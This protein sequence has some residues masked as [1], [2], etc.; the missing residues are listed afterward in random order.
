MKRL[1][2]TALLLIVLTVGA[3]A[4]EGSI[5]L[6]T[7]QEANDCDAT[8]TPYLSSEIH[9]MYFKSTSGPDGIAGAHFRVEI[10]AGGNV[11]LQSFTLHPN[12]VLSLGTV[13][14]AG[15]SVS[16]SGCTGAGADVLLIGTLTV[17]PMAAGNYTF[18]VLTATDIPPVID[19]P[20]AP[21]VAICDEGRSLRAVLG[22]WYSTPD[23]TCNVGTE[24][25]TWGAIKEM[26]KE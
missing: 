13:D 14:G 1:A 6:F 17:F 11:V 24:E 2:L 20:Y 18:R 10:P 15:I 22:G 12:I 16:Y 3:V 5:G 8:F 19:P 9:V 21:R 4:H 7:T 23:G 25:K 26:Y